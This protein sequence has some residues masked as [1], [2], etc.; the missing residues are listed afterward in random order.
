MGEMMGSIIALSWK[1]ACS[2]SLVGASLLAMLF[3]MSAVMLQSAIASKLA[4]T[5]RQLAAKI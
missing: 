2:S 3:M 4:P 5:V 1:R